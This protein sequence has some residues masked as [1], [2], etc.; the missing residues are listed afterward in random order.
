MTN[1]FKSICFGI[2]AAGS[3][4]FVSAQ[5]KLIDD[6]EKPGIWSWWKSAAFKIEQVEGALKVSFTNAGDAKVDNGY[7]C[8]GRDHAAETIDFT[9]LNALK[10]RC[11]LQADGPT[12]LRVDLK[13]VDDRVTN[14]LP[15]LKTIEPSTDWQDVYF[16]FSKDKFKQSWPGNDKVDP[17]EIKEFLIFVNPGNHSKPMSGTLLIDEFKLIAADKVPA[18]KK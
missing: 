6:F 4:N 2:L 17:E 10:I 14:A 7:N 13:D 1:K 15:I 8:F 18:D 11:K 5:E 3:A 12:K 9:K 16:V